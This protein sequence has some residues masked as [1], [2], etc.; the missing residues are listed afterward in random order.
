[1]SVKSIYLPNPAI[2]NHLIHVRD[3]EH[4]H[5]S[6]AR[7]QPGEELEVFDGAGNVWAA[8][9]VRNERRET[10]VRVA[11]HRFTRRDPYELVL[12][13]SLVQASAFELAIEK[14]V[15]T[16]VHRIV[17]IV[18]SRSNVRDARRSD[19]WQRIIIE[20][21]KQSKRYHIPIMVP[22]VSFEAILS[23]PASSRILFAERNGGP[24]QPALTGSPVLYL[25]GPEGGWTDAELD[26]AERRGFRL[27]GLGPTILRTETAAIVATALVRYELQK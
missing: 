20:A 16:G 10:I 25:V 24:L 13:L 15:E 18:A 9:V 5:L 8:V 17:P 6:V 14:A 12:G 11:A 21:S 23:F 7:V 26:S 27:V 2:E 1:M 4:R 22:A 3:D 19:R